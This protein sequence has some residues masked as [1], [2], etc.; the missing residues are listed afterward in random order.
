MNGVAMVRRLRPLAAALSTGAAITAGGAAI[1]TGRPSAV[2]SAAS[3]S[4]SVGLTGA[5]VAL[6]GSGGVRHRIVAVERPGT[7]VETTDHEFDVPLDWS[8]AGGESITVFAREV[9]SLKNLDKKDDLPWLVFLQGGPGGAAIRPAYSGWMKRALPDYRILLL[10]QRGTGLSTPVTSETFV[11]RCGT[12][13]AAGAAYLANFRADSIVADAEAIRVL[14]AGK[15][16][17][18]DTLGQSYGGFLTLHYLSAAPS[19]LRRCFVTGGLASVTRPPTDNYTAT[20][21]TVLARNAQVRK[22]YFLSF[23]NQNASILPRQA[24]DKHRDNSKR[25]LS[26]PCFLQYYRKYPEDVSRVRKIVA[27]LAAVRTFPYTLY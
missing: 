16:A 7:H 4:A 13:A 25:V 27:E 24:R 19:S 1:V 3:A 11:A 17:T 12:D 22:L 15:A 10:D 26:I 6:A 18:W 9:V 14:L 20:N 5:A 23:S 8:A 21:K 2:S